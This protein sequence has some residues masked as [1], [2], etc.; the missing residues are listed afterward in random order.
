MLSVRIAWP[1]GL[2]RLPRCLTA[3]IKLDVFGRVQQK[4]LIRTIIPPVRRGQPEY[5]SMRPTRSDETSAETARLLT[6]QR[7]SAQMS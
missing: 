7:R 2:Y 6:D 4:K 5:A 3:V 1:C